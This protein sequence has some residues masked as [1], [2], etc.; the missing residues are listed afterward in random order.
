M[1]MSVHKAKTPSRHM[2]SKQRRID[3]DM[4]LFYR[5]CACWVRS[6]RLRSAWAEAQADQSLPC[7]LSGYVTKDLRKVKTDQNELIPKLI[8]VFS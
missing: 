1:R 3:L 4:T 8:W 2:T 5:L 6:Q 7:A